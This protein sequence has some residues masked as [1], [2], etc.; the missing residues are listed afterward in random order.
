MGTLELDCTY[1]GTHLYWNALLMELFACHLGQTLILGV[2]Q[3]E[4]QNG[5]IRVQAPDLTKSSC[6]VQLEEDMTAGD[7]VDRFRKDYGATH[8]GGNK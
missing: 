1:I 7:I 6:W 2:L 5:R 3:L 4:N 8:I